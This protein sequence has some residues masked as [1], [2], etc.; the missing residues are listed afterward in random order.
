M[1]RPED[2]HSG[3]ARRQTAWSRASY[4]APKPP[5]PSVVAPAL[6]QLRKASV[7]T[8]PLLHAGRRDDGRRKACARHI[9]CPGPGDHTGRQIVEEMRPH[10]IPRAAGSSS[11]HS[12]NE[13]KRG[14]ARNKSRFGKK[15]RVLT[16]HAAWVSVVPMNTFHDW[17]RRDVARPALASCNNGGETAKSA[18]AERTGSVWGSRV[19]EHRGDDSS[20]KYTETA[21][22]ETAVLGKR[23]EPGPARAARQRWP[24]TMRY[25]GFASSR[26]FG[27]WPTFTTPTWCSCTNSSR[28]Q[29]ERRR[30]AQ[31]RSRGQLRHQACGGHEQADVEES[32][33]RCGARS[34][35]GLHGVGQLGQRAQR[36]RQRLPEAAQRPR[37]GIAQRRDVVIVLIRRLQARPPGGHDAQQR[38]TREQRPDQPGASQIDRQQRGAGQSPRS[39]AIWGPARS[40]NLRARLSQR[41]PPTQRRTRVRRG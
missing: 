8:R 12:S 11:W 26:S 16:R 2:R 39:A 5:L 6:K 3:R 36:A 25:E 30:L 37:R 28:R 29:A 34:Q 41:P 27:R 9:A 18:S 20:D 38:A 15:S 21:H 40:F 33:C 17:L 19:L 31:T 32:A 35:A 1:R 23:A 14:G 4:T 7:P 13:K 22:P 10:A 24:G